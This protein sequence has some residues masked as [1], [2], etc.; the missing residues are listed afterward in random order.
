M[1][2][3]FLRS[4]ARGLSPAVNNFMSAQQ[5]QR[6]NALQDEALRKQ[7]I[8][9]LT[10]QF[11][12]GL[13]ESPE[14]GVA[15][16]PDFLDPTSSTYQRDNR[17]AE[18]KRLGSPR[19]A[20]T[21]SPLT[22]GQLTGLKAVLSGQAPLSDDLKD[23]PVPSGYSNFFP[24]PKPPGASLTNEQVYSHLGRPM[25]QGVDPAAP[26]PKDYLQLVKPPSASSLPTTPEQQ[27]AYAEA[28]G[29]PLETV[30]NLPA[31]AF[32]SGM[33]G[34]G[35]QRKISERQ[36]KVITAANDR[37]NKSLNQSHE[38][39]VQGQAGVDERFKQSKELE[40]R[41]FIAQGTK[42]LANKVQA[43]GL[44]A[45]AN[46]FEIIDRNTG[47]FSS[48]RPNLNNLPSTL[49]TGVGAIPLIGPTMQSRLAQGRGQ[50]A[51]ETTQAINDYFNTAMKA[52]SGGAVT[53]SEEV[54]NRVAKGM[55][56]GATKESIAAGLKAARQVHQ[57]ME[58]NIF[59][60]EDPEA[61]AEYKSRPGA[62]QTLDERIAARKMNASQK[63]AASAQKLGMTPKE[64]DAI[65]T[66]PVKRQYSPSRNQ[67]KLIYADG[68]EEIVDGKK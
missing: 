20:G 47:L 41:K 27:K 34:A 22:A 40:K 35:T 2:N 67:T 7:K 46:N 63:R 66:A 37:Q 13:S 11:E 21:A 68:R 44:P 3:K 17:I 43:Q 32:F 4:F 45:M 33:N 53:A 16:N 42:D 1:K 25:P 59:S 58:G 60:A 31:S 28:T 15:V 29:A 51:L 54:R 12:S 62:Y 5:M 9:T 8:D 65:D 38:Q 26:F 36:D 49:E 52:I 56:P 10:K 19:A 64:M 30:K 55:A 18:L 50:G 24:A 39:F 57:Q 6:Q 61:V 14:G 23:L 48:P